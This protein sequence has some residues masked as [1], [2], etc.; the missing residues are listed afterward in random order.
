MFYIHTF[1]TKIAHTLLKRA[2]RRPLNESRCIQT[3]VYNTNAD[4]LV[5]RVYASREYTRKCVTVAVIHHP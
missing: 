4:V 2:G 3:Q 5:F 1:F